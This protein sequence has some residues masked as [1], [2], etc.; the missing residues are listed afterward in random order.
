MTSR[1]INFNTPILPDPRVMAWCEANGIDPSNV[2][3]E[4]GA[5]VEDGRITFVEFVRNEDG[6]KIIDDGGGDPH[7]R[8][9]LRTV[10]L[11]SAPE[12]HNL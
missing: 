6:V 7:Y 8:R 1:R 9:V 2:P 12:D 3:A 5:L 4:Q 11:L 10:P